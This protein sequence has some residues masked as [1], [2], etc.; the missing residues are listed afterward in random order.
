MRYQAILIQVQYQTRFSLPNLAQSS[1]EK[2]L[3]ATVA[4]CCFMARLPMGGLRFSSHKTNS[5]TLF[6]LDFPHSRLS[7]A[8]RSLA[9]SWQS[10]LLRPLHNEKPG[11]QG[12]VSRRVHTCIR[13]L[14]QLAPLSKMSGLESSSSLCSAIPT[15]CRAVVSHWLLC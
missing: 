1:N 6:S 12:H 10:S 2:Y 3:V 5:E 11:R 7:T 14:A 8:L 15:L 4:P 13:R 9:T